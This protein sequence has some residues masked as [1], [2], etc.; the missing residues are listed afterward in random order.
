[1]L[2]EP[3]RWH[4]DPRERGKPSNAEISHNFLLKL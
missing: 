2:I 1:V 3:D 4:F